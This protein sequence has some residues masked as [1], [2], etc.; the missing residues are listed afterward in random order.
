M[1]VR[2]QRKIA[3]PVL[4]VRCMHQ[5]D[6]RIPQTAKRRLRLSEFPD[7]ITSGKIK[8]D[9]SNADRGGGVSGGETQL[10]GRPQ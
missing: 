3:S 9:H 6:V 10:S 5:E 2:M 1:H 4:S 8:W 7:K